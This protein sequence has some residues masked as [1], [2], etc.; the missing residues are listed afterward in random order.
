M[1]MMGWDYMLDFF[2]NA[3]NIYRIKTHILWLE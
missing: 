3:S 2:E 1:Y